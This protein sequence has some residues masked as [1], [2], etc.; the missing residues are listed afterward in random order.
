MFSLFFFFFFLKWVWMF[1][2]TVFKY[3]VAVQVYCLTI[4]SGVLYIEVCARFRGCCCVACS[5]VQDHHRLVLLI[6]TVW[7]YSRK[8][9]VL[10]YFY[11][12]MQS[13]SFLASLSPFTSFLICS[14]ELNSCCFSRYRRL[15]LR[16]VDRF[17]TYS[18]P[19]AYY[20]STVF[21]LGFE[22]YIELLS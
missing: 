16:I 4:L 19:F 5:L 20:I 15:V 1:S 18:G 14:S 11:L 12:S 10:Q 21:I 13:V 22:A 7:I 3:L 2:W 17:C 6:Q 8:L 9:P